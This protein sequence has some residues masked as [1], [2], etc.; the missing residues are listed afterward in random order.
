MTSS[1][2]PAVDAEAAADW[3]LD[4]LTKRIPGK[5]GLAAPGDIQVLSPVYRGPAGITAL[6]GRLQEARLS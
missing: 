5:F 6:N 3:V 2:F 4:L 1:F